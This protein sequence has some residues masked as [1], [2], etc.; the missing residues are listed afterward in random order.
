MRK[1]TNM[2]GKTKIRRMTIMMINTIV[3]ISIEGRRK[4]SHT[5]WSQ[6]PL[7]SLVTRKA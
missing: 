2:A 6:I 4:R 7:F 5:E 3:S 1:P